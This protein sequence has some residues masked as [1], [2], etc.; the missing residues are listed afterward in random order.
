MSAVKILAVVVLLLLV[1]R[2]PL[3]VLLAKTI[4][5][6]ALKGHALSSVPERVHLYE[7]E[8]AEWRDAAGAEALSSALEGEGFRRVGDF[9]IPEMTGLR[10]RLL[11]RA[12]SVYANLH[13]HDKVGLW[14]E[15]AARLGDDSACV[16]TTLRPTGLDPP[17]WVARTSLP[18]ATVPALLR[19]LESLRRGRAVAPLAAGTIV[20]LW[21]EAYARSA[22][23]R[24]GKGMTDRELA[25]TIER[26]PGTL[27]KPPPAT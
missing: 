24:K 9:T 25:E 16:A 7:C 3:V 14:V 23:W 21:E 22:A 19:A 20:A 13:E 27:G 17:P 6:G 18:G 8:T 11:L 10:L 1:F 4:F 26:P 2:R 12:D 15:V 5:K